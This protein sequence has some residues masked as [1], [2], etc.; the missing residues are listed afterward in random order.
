MSMLLRQIAR[1]VAQKAAANP[2]AREIALKAAQ[3]AADEAKHIARQDD[4]AYAAG[5]AVRQ[6]LK[7]MQNGK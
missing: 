1:F 4:R 2:R 3:S 5:R 7:R 6:A